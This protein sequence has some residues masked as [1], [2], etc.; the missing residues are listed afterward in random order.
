MRHDRG[1]MSRPRHRRRRGGNPPRPD[2]R[3]SRQRPT[4]AGSPGH[5]QQGRRSA[6]VQQPAKAPDGAEPATTLASRPRWAWLRNPSSP[7]RAIP[8][9]LLVT[10][11]GVLASGIGVYAFVEQRIAAARPPPPMSGDLNIAVAEFSASGGTRSQ[12]A[13]AIADGLAASVFQYL[14]AQL[15]ALKDA[16]FEIQLRAPHD[17]GRAEG[18]S[19]QDRAQR[20]ANL[21]RNTNADVLIAA[22][23]VFGGGMTRVTPELY[24][25]EKKLANAQEL[26]GYHSLGQ[27]AIS[28]DPDSNAVA[29]RG[30]R[31]SLL[32][33]VSGVS[34]LIVGLGFYDQR[35][36]A[37]AAGELRAAE[38]AWTDP[39]GRKV[40][41]LFLGN[42]EGRRGDLARAETHYLRALHAD[43]GYWRAR[44]GL[45]A[46][47]FQR[48]RGTCERGSVHPRGLEAALGS[49]RAVLG[50]AQGSADPDLPVKVSFGLGQ[51]YLC[52]SQ[53]GLAD[54]W[55]QAQTQFRTVIEAYEH[56]NH[57][58]Q[59]LAAE[60]WAGLGLALLPTTA[61]ADSQAYRRAAQAYQQA[62]AL[63]LDPKRQAI[64]LDVLA[65]I[66]VK[67]NDLP[68]ACDAYRQAVTLDPDHASRYATE[69]RRLHQYGCA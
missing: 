59:E 69:Q 58:V 49:Y 44:L 43:P 48:A 45:A 50:A 22:N 64:F 57:R 40:V 36:Y 63:S 66:H 53:A 9:F 47:A 26:E 46:L 15:T 13:S 38:R 28:G 42:V 55:T 37:R 56:G 11:L 18:Q 54:D 21:A 27:A 4:D 68:R 2:E 25:A 24:L 7:A 16:G 19:T 32:A 65:H 6:T 14:P 41:E 67:L 3:R 35:Q 34:R 62:V 39:T 51:T 8:R 23:L 61:A 30:L 33:R 5:A 52:L 17:T 12:R 29:R 20:L 60:A 10:A 1:D 31:D